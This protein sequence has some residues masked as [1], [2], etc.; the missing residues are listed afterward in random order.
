M[1]HN[2]PRRL[3]VVAALA[4]LAALLSI[5]A[6]ESQ[7]SQAQSPVQAPAKRCQIPFPLPNP[8]DIGVKKFE[9]LLNSFL[10]QGCYR[11][12]VADSQIRNTGPF[13]NGTSFGTHNAVRI[14]YSPEAWD[15]LKHRNREGEIANGA[16]IVKEMFP[17][18]A[19]EGSKLSAWTIMVRDKKGSYDGWYWSFQAPGYAAD[20]PDLDYPDSGF[21]LYCLRCHA[22][23][24]KESTFSTVKNVEGDPIS[25]FISAPTMQ[26]L[27][28]ATKDEHQQVA[29]TK[30]VRGGPF[31]TARKTPEP[32]FLKLF[33]G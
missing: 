27:P 28:P 11:N 17:S 26:P 30:E 3:L 22:S 21:G 14:F 32:N 15:W 2:I 9:K 18:P 10:E 8:T 23:A 16:V 33:R 1:T 31:G 25:F 20:N 24:E 6:V 19:K 5:T 13:M 4:S 29:T 7:P 12:W